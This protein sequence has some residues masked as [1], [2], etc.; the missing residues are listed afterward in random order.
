M[1]TVP[2]LGLAGLYWIGPSPV[3]LVG[4]ASAYS[5]L[6]NVGHAVMLG[7]IYPSVRL[8]RS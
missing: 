6:H 4:L 7:P 1:C 3:A 2:G 5:G 8:P